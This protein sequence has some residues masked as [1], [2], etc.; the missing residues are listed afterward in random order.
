MIVLASTSAVRRRLLAAAGV[1]FEAAGSGVDE[2]CVKAGLT[3]SPPAIAA[4]LADAKALAVSRRRPDALV[5]GAD[6][7]LECDGRLFDKPA[8]LAEAAARLRLLRGRRHAL[9]AGLALARGGAVIWRTLA[10]TTLEM[11]D[12]S[13]AF[14]DAYLAR[15]QGPALATVGAYELE[16]EGAQLFASVEGDYFAVLGLP[17]LPLLEVLRAEGALPA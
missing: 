11:R 12:V 1:P 15:N 4:A 16:G 9:H 8:D 14:I 17:L 10:T 3:G 7:T 6:Q 5:I 13:D 2:A